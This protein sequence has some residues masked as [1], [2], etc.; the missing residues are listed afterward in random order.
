VSEKGVTDYFHRKFC[1]FQIPFSDEFHRKIYRFKIS[2][3]DDSHRKIYRFENSFS[4]FHSNRYADLGD[5]FSEVG[6]ITSASAPPSATL[7]RL[8]SRQIPTPTS[9]GSSIAIPRPPSRR[10]EMTGKWK[11]GNKKKKLD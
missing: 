4:F 11:A 10:S 1:R 5:I 8:N 2:L 3:S 9:G 6:D 7:S